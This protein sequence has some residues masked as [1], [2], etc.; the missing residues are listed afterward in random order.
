MTVLFPEDLGIVCPKELKHLYE[1]GAVSPGDGNPVVSG[2][3]QF[4]LSGYELIDYMKGKVPQHCK[5]LQSKYPN[6]FNNHARVALNKFLGG[7]KVYRM[8]KGFV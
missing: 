3:P 1:E 4:P 6:Y 7:R 2:Y 8:P 5:D